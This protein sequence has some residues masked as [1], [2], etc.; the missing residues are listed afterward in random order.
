MKII[1]I[2]VLFA[3]LTLSM[4]TLIDVIAGIRV[5]ESIHSLSTMFATTTLQE[6]ICIMIFLI[7]PFIQVAVHA[8]YQ[9]HPRRKPSQ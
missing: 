7:L 6:F 9:R 3:V 2:Y 8:Y 5:T 1:S 4:I